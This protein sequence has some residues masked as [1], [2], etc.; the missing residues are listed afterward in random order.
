MRL[1]ELETISTWR[2]F[3]WSSYSISNW[4]IQSGPNGCKETRKQLGRPASIAGLG[5]RLRNH[6][7]EAWKYSEMRIYT[8]AFGTPLVVDVIVTRCKLIS[9]VVVRQAIHLSSEITLK[10]ERQ[11]LI[12]TST[13][14]AKTFYQL[15]K[16]WLSTCGF[17]KTFR[18]NSL[19]GS[20]KS[21]LIPSFI[22][23]VRRGMRHARI[24]LQLQDRESTVE[25]YVEDIPDGLEIETS[26][27]VRLL[28]LKLIIISSGELRRGHIWR[29]RTWDIFNSEIVTFEVL[30]E[31]TAYLMFLMTKTICTRTSL[32]LRYAT[33]SSI[34]SDSLYLGTLMVVC[35]FIF[36]SETGGAGAFPSKVS[37]QSKR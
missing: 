34:V 8:T 27:T 33:S 32:C 11:P 6:Q 3:P 25:N 4:M 13:T 7:L 26:L 14:V 15:G 24:L 22:Q 19:P 37:R 1:K 36:W 5:N 10:V 30:H 29:T 20:R 12:W 2:Q 21:C 9:L 35:I 17:Q 31:L 16:F 18:L 23:N 28:H